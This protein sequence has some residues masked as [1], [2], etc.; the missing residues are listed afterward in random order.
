MAN[1]DIEVRQVV[2]GTP[3][4]GSNATRRFGGSSSASTPAPRPGRG[5]CLPW[6]PCGPHRAAEERRR[7]QTGEHA[8]A[9]GCRGEGKG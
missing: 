5:R 4:A 1:L 7:R 8:V 9:D 6:L 2:N 3:T